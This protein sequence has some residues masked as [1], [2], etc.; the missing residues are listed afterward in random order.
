MTETEYRYLQMNSSNVEMKKLTNNS[1][2][3]K[4]IHN[5]VQCDLEYEANFTMLSLGYYIILL[6]NK[7]LFISISIYR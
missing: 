4:L 1:N 7:Y 5:G 6:C 2:Y 3:F